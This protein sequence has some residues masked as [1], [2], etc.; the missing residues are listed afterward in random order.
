MLTTERCGEGS[1]GR[2]EV[3]VKLSGVRPDDDEEGSE[4]ASAGATVGSSVCKGIV[5]YGIWGGGWWMKVG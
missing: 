3:D 2:L 5:G 1:D 4:F